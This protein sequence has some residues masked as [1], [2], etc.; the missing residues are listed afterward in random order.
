VQNVTPKRT[1]RAAKI[2]NRTRSDFKYPTEK[3]LDS[4]KFRFG[5]RHIPSANMT[6]TRKWLP[7]PV[8]TGLSVTLIMFNTAA[9]P[10][11]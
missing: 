8:L 7:I 1:R 6:G 10:L 2:S 5:I 9:L 11:Q 4:V 3:V